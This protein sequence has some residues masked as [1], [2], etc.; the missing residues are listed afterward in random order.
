MNKFINYHLYTVQAIL[1]QYS[2]KL[3]KLV[4]MYTVQVLLRHSTGY[5]FHM[6]INLIQNFNIYFLRFFN[7]EFEPGGG[8]GKLLK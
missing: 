8:M 7:T 2:V 4:N 3:L 5:L 6:L 1:G